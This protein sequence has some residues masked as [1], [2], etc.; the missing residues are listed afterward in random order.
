M[1][2]VFLRKHRFVAV[3]KVN[4]TQWN[5]VVFEQTPQQ[6]EALATGDGGAAMLPI[7]LIPC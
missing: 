2:V 3:T 6:S 5:V 7:M 4:P 1:P